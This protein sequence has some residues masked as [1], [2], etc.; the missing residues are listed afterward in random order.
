MRKEAL[1]VLVAP[2]LAILW[3]GV[4]PPRCGAG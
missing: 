2:M 3:M 4:T 1:V